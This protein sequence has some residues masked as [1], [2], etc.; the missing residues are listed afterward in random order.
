MAFNFSHDMSLLL[1]HVLVISNTR[2]ACAAR[3]MVVVPCVCV[4]G[5]VCMCLC[6]YVSVCSFLPPRGYRS[7]N[8]GTNGFNS[9]Q[10]FFYNCG[11]C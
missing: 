6:V 8:I 1:C 4:C 7:Q 9:M 10:I 3:V 5:C 11:F 2:C